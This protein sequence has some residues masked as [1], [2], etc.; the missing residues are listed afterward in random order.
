MFL[1]AAPRSRI[2]RPDLHGGRAD[3]FGSRRSLEKACRERQVRAD[4]PALFNRLHGGMHLVIVEVRNDLSVVEAVRH[5]SNSCTVR[6]WILTCSQHSR[7]C[8]TLH[9][10]ASSVC[11]PR[12]S[13][14]PWRSSRGACRSAPAR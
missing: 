2:V 12:A 4:K 1:A 5:E 6:A 8:P 11:S 10:Y 13:R 14:F 9:G 7:L 3:L